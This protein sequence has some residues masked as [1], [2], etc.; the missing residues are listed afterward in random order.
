MTVKTPTAAVE[1]DRCGFFQSCGLALARCLAQIPHVDWTTVGDRLF[2]PCPQWAEG[3]APLLSEEHQSSVMALGVFLLESRGQCA[4]HIVPYLIQLLQALPQATISPKRV[5]GAKIPE[6]EGFSFS[7]NTLLCDIAVTCPKYREAIFQIQ[8]DMFLTLCQMIDDAQT[9]SEKPLA[10]NTRLHLCRSTVPLLFGMCRAVGRF[11]YN[12]DHLTC[13]LFPPKAHPVAHTRVH[14]RNAPQ[15]TFSNFRSIIPRSLSQ[16]FH[17]NNGHIFDSPENIVDLSFR[18]SLRTELMVNQSQRQSIEKKKL[19]FQSQQSVVPYDPTTYFFHKAGSSFNQLQAPLTHARANLEP[20][21]QREKVLFPVKHLQVIFEQICQTLSKDTLEFLNTIALD[22]YTSGTLKIFP[23]KTFSETTNLVLIS[24][25]RELIQNTT[26]LR[27]PFVKEVQ[28]FVKGLFL[29][30][31]NELQ[32]RDHEASEREDEAQETKAIPHVNRFKLN[33]LINAVCVD[34]LVW[35]TRD[36]LASNAGPSSLAHGCYVMLECELRDTAF[37]FSFMVSYLLI[38]RPTVPGSGADNLVTKLTDKINSSNNHKLILAHLPLIMVCIEGLGKLAE[39]FPMLAKQSSDCLREFLA[40]PSKLLI[41]LSRHYHHQNARL[42]NQAQAG[43]PIVAKKL[44]SVLVTQS[45]SSQSMRPAHQPESRADA[46]RIAFEKLRDCAIENLCKGLMSQME[47]DPN[48]IPA[49]VSSFTTRLFQ[50]DHV[51]DKE[52]FISSKNAILA[53]GHIAVTLRESED[54]TKAVLKFLLQ[55]F[56]SN[57]GSDHYYDPLLIDQMGCIVISRTKADDTYKDIMQKFK[58]IIKE[59]SQ[60][61]SGVGQPTDRKNKYQLCSGSVINALANIAANIHPDVELMTDFLQKLME[62]YVNIGLEVKRKLTAERETANRTKSKGNLG[63]LIPV[64]AVLL[65]RMP[66][67]DLQNPNYRTKKL[68]SDFWLYAVVFGFTKEED[69]VWPQDWYD[70]VKEIALKAPKLTFAS[71]ERSEIRQLTHTQA[72]SKDGIKT[73]ELQELKSHLITVLGHDSTVAKLIQNYT[74]PIVIYLMSVYNLEKLRITMCADI[75]TFDKLF[76]YLEDRA[77]QVDKTMIYDCILVIINC[78]F[79]D[80]FLPAIGE[81]PKNKERDR[82]LEAIAVILLIEFNNP[83]KNI[84]KFADQFLSELVDKFSYLLWSKSVLY[85]MLNALHQ[86]SLTVS[87]EDIQVVKIGKMERKV[88]LLDTPNERGEILQEFRQRSRQFIK[89]SVTWAPDT[90]L[91]HLQ[92]YINEI[93]KESYSNHSGVS[94]A[95]ECMQNFSN[96]N[97]DGLGL[98]NLGNVIRP[99]SAKSDSSRFMI[100]MSN[101]Q[102]NMSTVSAMLSLCDNLIRKHEVLNSFTLDLDRAAEIIR[103][104]P[105]E[106]A[107]ANEVA[108]QILTPRKRLD[109]PKAIAMKKFHDALWKI[110]SSLILLKP[111]IDDKLMFALTRSPLKVFHSATMK[112]IVECWNWLL[113]AR[114]D[115]EMKFL[116]EMI[117]AWHSSQTMGLFKKDE[118]K[119]SPLAPDE[120]MK[121]NLHPNTPDIEPHDIWIRF[122][123]ERIEVAKYCSQEQI[124]MFTHMLQRTLDISVGKEKMAMSRHI[125]AA[126]T[127]FRLLSCGMSLLQGDVLPKSIA[128]NVLRQRIYSA[129]LDYFCAEKTFPT[130][131]DMALSEDIQTL[132]RFWATMHQDRKHIRQSAI[133]GDLD[134]MEGAAPL[135]AD[136]KS[137]TS[138]FYKTPSVA[139]GWMTVSSGNNTLNKR[140]ASR[141]TRP[142]INDSFVKDYNKKRG[143]IL[144]LLSVEIERLTVHENPLE[145]RETLIQLLGNRDNG[146]QGNTGKQFDDAMKFLDEIRW[147][148]PIKTMREYARNAWEV[149]PAL[150]VFLP[151]RL[152]FSDVLEREVCRMV[153]TYPAECSFIPR[154]LDYFLTKE[155]LENDAAELPYVLTWAKCSPVRALSLLCP[156]TLPTHPLTA[157]YAVSVLHSYPAEAVLFYIP[158]LVQA[159]RYDDLGFVKEFI[160]KISKE[161]NLV[162]H[163]LIWNIQTNMYKDEDGEEKDPV[164]YDKLLPL[165]DAIVDGLSGKAQKFYRREFEFFRKVTSV[166]GKIKEFEK[167][168]PRKAACIKALQE[169][170]VS[171]G[172]YLPSNPDSLVLDIDKSSGQPMQ[173]A[174]K[175]PYL[176]RFKCGV[177]ECVPDAKS[178]DQI[179]RKANTDLFDYFKKEFGEETS[180]GF[181]RARRNFTTSM[182]AYSVIV[183]LLQIKDRHNGNIMIDKEGHLIHIDFGFMFESSPGGNLAFEPDM[184]LTQE[185]VDIMGGKIEAPQF[186]AF[187][188][189]CVQA[190][191]AIRPYWREIIYLVQLML[192]TELPCFRGQTIEQLRARLQPNMSEL[193]ASAFMVQVIRQSFLNFRTRA[194]DILQYHQ[195]QIPY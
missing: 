163:Q 9:S 164:M 24:M 157:Q 16:T 54:N 68:F 111:A 98:V 159:T 109:T 123:Q 183:F 72:I 43:A 62:M 170:T 162:A 191:L 12:A 90:V 79:R 108:K 185:F 140:S 13:K 146:T 23:Y 144:A 27:P 127:R 41:R 39:K 77:I 22:V 155:P 10:T 81:K 31:Q 46:S 18:P 134:W 100:S 44:P 115:I 48:C 120:D 57:S 66:A 175:A 171:H 63:V 64:I 177:I 58:E 142:A 145:T 32:S 160:K 92:E 30:G 128:K 6:C 168:H 133:A 137:V 59:A 37:I 195:N 96:E 87:L 179:G 192:D 132:L 101:R 187:M 103:L 150:A 61:I 73:S 28:A 19:S 71:G 110:T 45:E 193:E 153:R 89:T 67:D 121:V 104:T 34:I 116:Q 74:F 113:S 35:A 82:N 189:L 80:H 15:K 149:S 151:Q 186:K 29:S 166:S 4:E 33:V 55:W 158:Q 130:Q 178:R 182:A 52:W 11:S 78:L 14:T 107:E 75:D 84:R 40:N 161:S 138:E 97:Q 176:A 152:T 141:Q 167:G 1:S 148:M 26:E 70:G 122:I 119:F 172:C 91:S 154:A 49:L 188:E 53:L 181:K 180:Q 124:I 139:G 173:S 126:G 184:K 118:V 5:A 7:L 156:R 17:S 94:L 174:A 8:T 50:P 106:D 135:E 114:P 25:L 105:E 86:L 56:D 93:T 60:M 131:S 136:R 99:I 69:G 51:C 169:I 165:R 38:Q 83:N 42:N 129:S 36:E 117:F 88:F 125:A 85:G 47:V 20:S 112:V 147:R 3:H 65:R 21:D 2:T 102:S 194:Y 143:L 95:T 190:Y 76:D